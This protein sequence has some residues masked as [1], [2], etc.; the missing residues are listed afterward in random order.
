[1]RKRTYL[2]I[3]EESNSTVNSCPPNHIIIVDKFSVVIGEVNHQVNAAISN[4]SGEI[5]KYKLAGDDV[6]F[7]IRFQT[8]N[9][10]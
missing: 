6:Y 1:M 5:N 4:Q 8:T 9:V 10:N 2:E 7:I 3:S